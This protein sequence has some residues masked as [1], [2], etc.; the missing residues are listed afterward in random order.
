MNSAVETSVAS[1]QATPRAP[2]PELSLFRLYALRAAYL[3][4]AAGLGVY[5]WP[6]VIQYTN[7]LAVTQGIR[8]ALLA[9]L[10]LTARLARAGCLSRTIFQAQAQAEKATDPINSE[11]ATRTKPLARRTLPRGKASGS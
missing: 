6:S 1:G 10:G 2:V 8:L 4:M 7:E 11:V 3:V 5:V 9:G